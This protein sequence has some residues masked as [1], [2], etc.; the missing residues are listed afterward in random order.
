MDFSAAAAGA[1][2]GMNSIDL[3]QLGPVSADYAPA[4]E[5]RVMNADDENPALTRQKVGRGSHG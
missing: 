3:L 4:L 2:A 1:K 5:G